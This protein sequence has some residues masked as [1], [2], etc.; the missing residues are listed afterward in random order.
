MTKLNIL[1][2]TLGFYPA[3]AWGGPVKIVHQNG[4]ELMRR[5]HN[6]TIYCTNLLN[7]HK[8]IA[9][10]TFERNIDGL[11]V[12]YFNTWNFAWWPGTLGPILLPDLPGYLRKEITTFDIV[13][14]NGYRNFMNL[15]IARAARSKGIPFV[16]QPHGA[17]QLIVNSIFVKQIYDRFW[18]NQELSGVGMILAGQQ[19]E[20]EQAIKYGIP[21]ERIRLI[22][23]GV[24]LA[25]RNK[26]PTS[27][28]FRRRINIP[29]DK[30]LI[31]F[32]GRINRKKGTD[33]LVH[34]FNTLK[35]KDAFLAIVGP[36]DGQ[37]DEVQNLITSY[38]LEDRVFLPGLLIG[39]EVYA[40]YQDADV[41]VLPCRTDTYP[42][43][44]IEACLAG[45]PMVVTNGLEIADL[46]RDRVALVTNF[47][48]EEFAEA[49]ARILTDHSLY[50][51]LRS[52]CD[53]LMQDTFS[54]KAVGDQL[55]NIYFELK[56]GC[57]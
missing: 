13:H 17:M 42:M 9:P 28:L 37:L 35:V 7:K 25:D 33:M 46:L 50:E 34:A 6:V 5:G 39:E 11:R 32:L 14:I 3:S 43:A 27:G 1:M 16:L 15:P 8:R 57:L 30:P 55:E 49:I 26:F 24:D 41:F 38:G 48:P 10:G 56:S 44:I 18:G 2:S 40:A 31:L 36:D 29:D 51:S 12:V 4:R 20:A 19:S 53:A 21:P 23:N 47:D 54:I 45:K 22:H 52:N